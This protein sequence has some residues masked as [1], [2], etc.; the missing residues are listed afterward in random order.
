MVVDCSLNAFSTTLFFNPSFSLFLGIILGTSE[1]VILAAF[2]CAPFI[3]YL[4]YGNASALYIR[5]A[6][7]YYARG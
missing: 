1:A 5:L 3:V 6:L 7:F 2:R 4:I